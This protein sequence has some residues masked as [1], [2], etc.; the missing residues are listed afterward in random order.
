MLEQPDEKIKFYD[1]DRRRV[2]PKGYLID[3]EGNIVDKWGNIVIRKDLLILDENKR[4]NEI[5][6]VF[7]TGRFYS[8][9]NKI[10]M[11]QE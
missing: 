11:Q 9:E 1:L 7:R 3:E 10:Q 4:P 5:P 6:K 2:N 8:K